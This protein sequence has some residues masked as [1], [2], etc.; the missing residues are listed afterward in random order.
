MSELSTKGVVVQ[1]WG[2]IVEENKG[3]RQGRWWNADL[4]EEFVGSREE[5][6]R[7]LQALAEGF[8]PTHP[9]MG[10]R[11]KRA[12]RTSDGFLVLYQGASDEYPC[13]FIAADMIFDSGTLL[14]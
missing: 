8:V 9:A 3:Y 7:R 14:T 10:V 12:Y 2:L 11:R 4:M 6:M 1:R 13:R 5:A